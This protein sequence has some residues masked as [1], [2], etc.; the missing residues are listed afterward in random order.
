MWA[1]GRVYRHRQVGWREGKTWGDGKAALGVRGGQDPTGQRGVSRQGRS[2][3]QDELGVPDI[4]V[5]RPRGG[6]VGRSLAG[7][8]LPS[9]RKGSRTLGRPSSCRESARGEA[10]G[11]TMRAPG[12]AVIPGTKRGSREKAPLWET[13][14]G[15]VCEQRLVSGLPE[16]QVQP[17]GCAA[18]APGEG[19][20]PRLGSKTLPLEVMRAPCFARI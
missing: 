16:A 19:W 2:A 3:L 6:L 15:L 5:G 12:G 7:P 20:G 10:A 14:L 13:R 9:R 18:P 4:T 17:A 1:K 8:M 11:A